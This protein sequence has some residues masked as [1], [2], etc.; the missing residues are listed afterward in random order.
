[1]WSI[2]VAAGWPIWPLIFTSVIGLAIII[3]RILMLK[4]TQ[5]APKGLTDDVVRTLPQFKDQGN[6]SRLATHSALGSVL[7]EGLRAHFRSTDI[8]EAMESKGIEIRATLEK[9]L[10]L[11]GLIAT[12]AP[13]MGLLGTVV[14]MIEIFAVQGQTTQT[15][16][17][18]ASGI[19]V[20]LYNTAFGLIVAIPALIAHKLFKVKI[21]N[22]LLSLEVAVRPLE[23]TLKNARRTAQTRPT[24]SR[25]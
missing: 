20:A 22:L 11:L 2:I 5:V 8:T 9:H 6:L 19:A 1:M 18:L 23:L 15:P 4:K 7:A 25:A 16:E 10:D 13:L 17:A 21:N 24:P 3:E 12:A 14:G